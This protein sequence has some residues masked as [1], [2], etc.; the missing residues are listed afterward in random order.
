M[1]TFVRSSISG[2]ATYPIYS[3]RTLSIENILAFALSLIFT[4]FLPRPAPKI[5][6]LI[7]PYYS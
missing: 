3:L 1:E 4:D 5:F 7:E 6:T 2:I